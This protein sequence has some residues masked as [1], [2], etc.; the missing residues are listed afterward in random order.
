M[1]SN[2]R[3][4]R[5]ATRWLSIPRKVLMGRSTGHHDRRWNL[6]GSAF[7]RPFIAQPP[8]GL[9]TASASGLLALKA[10]DRFFA[11]TFGYGQSLLDLDK[12]ERQFG[13]KVCLNR[14][15]PVQ[16]RSMDTKTYEDVV[17][18]KRTQVSENSNIP[19]FGIDVTSDILR[20]VT[21]TPHNQEFA[22]TLSGSDSLVVNRPL[23]PAAPADFCGSFSLLSKTI[24]IKT[25]LVG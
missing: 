14:I 7:V 15:D 17:V 4:R 5:C 21:G 20:A 23:E 1:R 24:V 12:I 19:A 13:L 8:D 22:K 9:K 18:A 25:V 2:Q 16:M 11:V 10:S 6:D 3:T